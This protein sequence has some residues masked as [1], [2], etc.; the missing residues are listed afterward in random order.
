LV[1]A[2]AFAASLSGSP[3]V[4]KPPPVEELRPY[5]PWHVDWAEKTCVIRRGFGSEADPIILQIERFAP[6]DRFQVLL[7]GKRL[8][9]ITPPKRLSLGY[10][11]G[12]FVQTLDHYMVG[13]TKGGLATIFISSSALRELIVGDPPSFV[14]VTPEQEAAVGQISLSRVRGKEIVLK[15][16]SLGPVFVA[17]R[18]CTDQLI[19]AWGLIPAQ[20]FR[21]TRPATPKT[22]PGSW[23]K[24]SDYPTGALYTGA[25]AIVNFRVTVDENGMPVACE[26]QRSY[27]GELFDRT[28][29]QIIMRSARFHPALDADSKPIRSYYTNTVRWMMGGQ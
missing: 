29:C 17:M 15:T 3:L 20:Q 16:G 27:S 9:G 18:K 21:L 1:A 4:A 2:I 7:T 26:L 28:T 14:P 6:G 22:N 10:G 24:S 25:Q 23:L 5:T 13:G 11:L 12:G 19:E 8:S